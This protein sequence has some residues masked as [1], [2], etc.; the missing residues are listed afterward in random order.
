MTARPRPGAHRLVPLLLA[1][2]LVAVGLSSACA[3]KRDIFF[4]NHLD[5]AMTVH[6]DGD[7]LLILRPGVT[8]AIPYATA[9]WAW[10]RTIEIRDYRTGDVHMRLVADSTDLIQQRWLIDIR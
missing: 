4:R 5:R 2:V 10:P 8:E 9:A 3:D 7:R 1:L 6:V